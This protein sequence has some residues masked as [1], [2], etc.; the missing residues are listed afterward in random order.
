MLTMYSHN[1]IHVAEESRIMRSTND[2][3]VHIYIYTSLPCFFARASRFFK[4][5]EKSS[6]SGGFS[7][8]SNKR[9]RVKTLAAN[10]RSHA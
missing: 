1:N 4:R 10:G 2:R 3:K 7:L 8:L 9:A 5:R 6:I